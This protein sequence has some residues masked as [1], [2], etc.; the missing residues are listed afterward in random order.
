MQHHYDC[1]V[2]LG[3]VKLLT[4]T[5]DVQASKQLHQQ[6]LFELHNRRKCSPAWEIWHLQQFLQ[7]P[8]LLRGLY[9]TPLPYESQCD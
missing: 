3:A 8:L 6:W 7:A 9:L 5:M 2:G 4:N 1:A